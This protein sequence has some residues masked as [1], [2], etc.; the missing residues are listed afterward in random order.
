[1]DKGELIQVRL[2]R[3]NGDLP[4]IL[5]AKVAWSV[6][7]RAGVMFLDLAAED[8]AALGQFMARRGPALPKL[9]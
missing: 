3:P 7:D 9:S 6:E 1:M 5:N 4:L 2:A 8:R